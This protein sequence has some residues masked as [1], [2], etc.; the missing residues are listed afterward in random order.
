MPY[1]IP[2]TIGVTDNNNIVGAKPLTLGDVVDGTGQ[3]ILDNVRC[4]GSEL[5]LINCRH[6][7][8]GTHDCDHSEDSGV[9]CSPDASG[10]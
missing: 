3:I 6:G 7:G 5:R 9:R 2:L 10:I 8:A 4:T 1:I